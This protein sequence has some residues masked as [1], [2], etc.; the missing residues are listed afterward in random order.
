[1][2]TAIYVLPPACEMVQE[3]YGAVVGH[4]RSTGSGNE[5]E[6]TCTFK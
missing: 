4:V 1:M 5:R 3:I 2:D 6:R